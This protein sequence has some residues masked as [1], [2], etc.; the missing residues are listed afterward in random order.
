MGTAK[1]AQPA[2]LVIGLLGIDSAAL[3]QGLALVTRRFGV[4]DAVMEPIPF[5]H[6]RYYLDELGSNPLRTFASFVDLIPRTSLP[7]IKLLTQ[8]LEQVLASHGKRTV[9]LDPGYLTPG[10]LF[11]ASTKDQ[12][13]RVYI[14]DGIYVEPTLYFREGAFYPFEWTYPDYRGGSYFNFLLRARSIL[15]RQLRDAARTENPIED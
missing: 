4:P 2:K 7:D 6:T 11:L 3:D 5:Q 1:A 13:Q 9:N 8:D 12:R 14:R 10:Q 15:L